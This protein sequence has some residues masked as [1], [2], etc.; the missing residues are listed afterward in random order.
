MPLRSSEAGRAPDRAI[1]SEGEA[2]SHPAV[3]GGVISGCDVTS[4]TTSP[5]CLAK[6]GCLSLR[7][8]TIATHK[9]FSVRA[10]KLKREITR[11]PFLKCEQCSLGQVTLPLCKMGTF[12]TW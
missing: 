11:L 6:S 9:L 3:F 12:Q 5:V 8:L 7:F 2:N 1:A 10:A 4:Y